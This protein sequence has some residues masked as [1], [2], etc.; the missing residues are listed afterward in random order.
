MALCF[1][2]G[3]LIITSNTSRDL[4]SSALGAWC[5]HGSVIAGCSPLSPPEF[6]CPTACRDI[7]RCWVM[8]VPASSATVDVPDPK[9]PSPCYHTAGTPKNMHLWGHPC[10]QTGT[11]RIWTKAVRHGQWKKCL[12]QIHGV[13]RV[14]KANSFSLQRSSNV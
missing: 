9:N 4:P 2:S 3:C 6:P 11:P 7:V 12:F 14:F 5:G 8:V 10:H 13:W 1:N